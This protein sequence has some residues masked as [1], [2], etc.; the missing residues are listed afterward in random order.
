MDPANNQRKPYGLKLNPTPEVSQTAE[1]NFLNIAVRN[2]FYAHIACFTLLLATKF[3][4]LF[5]EVS[6]RG[7]KSL[8]TFFSICIYLYYMFLAE[9]ALRR[10]RPQ[11]KKPKA[12]ETMDKNNFV[13]LDNIQPL[14]PK[15]IS[16]AADKKVLGSVCSQSHEGNSMVI[17]WLELLFFLANIF[18][19]FGSLV[20]AWFDETNVREPKT[21]DKIILKDFRGKKKHAKIHIFSL[22]G[23]EL[24]PWGKRFELPGI[25]KGDTDSWPITDLEPVE[26]KTQ[27]AAIN[28]EA[29]EVSETEHEGG[30][31]GEEAAAAENEPADGDDD[32]KP[33]PDTT[34]TE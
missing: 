2:M 33:A 10:Y 27:D 7:V 25:E 12:G 1:Q 11:Y 5:V 6:S 29:A 9:F 21:S 20:G 15:L 34:A 24:M 14:K 28:D 17:L 3:D 19:I 8:L 13:L 32:F 4:I 23:L 18:I 22:Q 31:D 26:K 16:Y 30:E